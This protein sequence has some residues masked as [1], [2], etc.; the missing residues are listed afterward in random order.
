ME[1]CNRKAEEEKIYNTQEYKNYA[2]RLDEVDFKIEEYLIEDDKVY[3]DR[4]SLDPSL[5]YKK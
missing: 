5:Y 1:A 3:T 4:W 2:M